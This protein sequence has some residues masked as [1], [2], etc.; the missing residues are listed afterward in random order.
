MYEGIT[1]VKILKQNMN[2]YNSVERALEEIEKQIQKFLSDG[3][4]L[5]DISTQAPLVLPGEYA[6]DNYYVYHFGKKSNETTHLNLK[7]NN[8]S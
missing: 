7:E 3:W 2:N 8:E 4:I 1:E 5:L 6:K